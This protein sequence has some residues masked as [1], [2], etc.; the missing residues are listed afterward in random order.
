MDRADNN[1]SMT[2]AF[3]CAPPAPGGSPGLRCE[4]L[5]APGTP[6]NPGLPPGAIRRTRIQSERCRGVVMVIAL[7]AIIL[8]ASLLF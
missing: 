5:T 1:P 6:G 7:L 4:L 2:R 3:I 8:I